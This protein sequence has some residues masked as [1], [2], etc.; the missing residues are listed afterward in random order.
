MAI[1]LQ[2]LI[3]KVGMDIS[4][5][6]SGIDDVMK[7]TSEA[8]SA[9]GSIGAGLSAGLTV[10]LAAIGAA[11]M[12]AS[13]QIKAGFRE[14]IVG[15]GEVGATLTGLK[16]S[17]KNVFAGVPESA[18]EVGVAIADLHR[19]LDLTGAP[20]EALATQF[21]NLS[22]IT[23]QSVE[24]LI[25]S[26]TRAFQAFKISTDQQAGSLDYLF[27]VFQKTGAPVQQL[28]DELTQFGPI[29]RSMGLDFQSSAALLGQFE[30]AGVPATAAMTGLRKALSEMA[31]AGL[32]TSNGFQ[33]VV[34]WIKQAGT[35]AQGLQRSIEIFG[36]KGGA[37]MFD[38]IKNGAVDIKN[39]ASGFSEA[40]NSINETTEKVET[41][42]AK[43]TKTWHE[44]QIALAPIGDILKG[45][46][47]DALVAIRPLIDSVG[48]LGK[49]FAG[50]NSEQKSVVVDL[51]LIAGAAGPVVL[52]F[53]KLVATGIFT[54]IVSL[55]GGV[56]GLGF[57]FSGM[58][59]PLT[60]ATAQIVTFLGIAGA[61]AGVIGGIGAAVAAQYALMKGMQSENPT[62]AGLAGGMNAAAALFGVGINTGIGSKSQLPGGQKMGPPVASGSAAA[63][64]AAATGGAGANALDAAAAKA[65]LDNAMGLLGVVDL[66]ANVKKFQD[67]YK[68]IAASGRATTE[69][70]E[71]AWQKV[72]DAM[73]A[74]GSLRNPWG[75]TQG[76]PKVFDAST[77]PTVESLIAT[78]AAAKVARDGFIAMKDAQKAATDQM[79]A[80]IEEENRFRQN[81]FDPSKI[82][83]GLIDGNES[84]GAFASPTTTIAQMQAL[85]DAAK[86][87]DKQFASMSNP[88]GSINK[89]AEKFI[90]GLEKGVVDVQKMALGADTVREA[91]SRLGVSSKTDLAQVWTDAATAQAAYN[92]GTISAWQN[93]QA[94]ISAIQKQITEGGW[95]SDL[96][97]QLDKIKDSLV[98]VGKAVHDNVKGAVDALDTGLAKAILDFH[99]F[100][101]D[102]LGTLKSL[103]ESVFT[104][105]FKALTKPLTDALTKTITDAITPIAKSI[106]GFL[107]IGVQSA[108]SVA[109]GA[110]SAAGGAASAAG[111]AASKAGGTA[112]S[113]ASSIGSI[114]GTVNMISGAVGAISSVIGNFQN[115]KMETTMNAI[116]ESTRYLKIGLVTQGDSLL[117]DSHEIR[118]MLSDFFGA[119]VNFG[120]LV[121][122]VKELTDAKDVSAQIRD[123]LA[124]P[125]VPLLQQ[126][127]DGA[128]V[129]AAKADDGSVIVPSGLFDSLIKTV[130]DASVDIVTSIK[131]GIQRLVDL[132]GITKDTPA[133]TP[134]E[135]VPVTVEPSPEAPATTT[136]YDPSIPYDTPQRVETVIPANQ[137]V[138]QTLLTVNQSIVNGCA[139]IVAQLQGMGGVGGTGTAAAATGDT[140]TTAPAGDTPATTSDIQTATYRLLDGT[141]ESTVS[142]V[143]GVQSVADAVQ[144]SAAR[145]IGGF[146]DLM[147]QIA[148]AAPNR[149]SPIEPRYF[150]SGF[151]DL[152]NQ[153]G[154]YTSELQQGAAKS[155]GD[156]S[157]VLNPNDPRNAGASAYTA[158]MPE[159][160]GSWSPVSY[161]PSGLNSGT[162]VTINNPI[163]RNPSDAQAI[164][165]LVRNQL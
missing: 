31:K 22:H 36:S 131:D 59:G 98:D 48:D 46:M 88:F 143:N 47:K 52:A 148:V 97:A 18:K 10:P 128:G 49:A 5:Y 2:E 77:L 78:G 157:N 58:E 35:E 138:V 51:G 130:K 122:L 119:K 21:L 14:I 44:F 106:A 26:T 120:V 60:A 45:F 133:P 64:G 125:I 117:N 54:N 140:G 71:A 4:D 155:V 109:G 104:T 33:D 23:G 43:L 135:P 95:T 146:T 94:Q 115:A 39:L 6:T 161:V 62:I 72:T 13:G 55:A 100:G 89:D 149:G 108:T 37:S 19:R 134:V 99:N 28:S 127:A 76:P 121:D 162:N 63:P 11:A 67:A 82:K 139:S 8:G 164:V 20:L 85:N 107:G 73:N 75:F 15:T 80:M 27:T 90:D 137:N 61:I 29:L 96:Q 103:G 153:P 16:D 163:F 156:F 136:P 141:G 124:N 84:V 7:K 50:L 30:K 56:R 144:Y 101:K 132:A 70:L 160:N 118:N 102:M 112:G 65:A 3:V 152:L 158:P 69:Q 111:G 114:A 151:T 159:L 79:A 32:D 113:A 165:D 123:V 9:L 129:G 86:E 87:L 40:G 38:A 74:A 92:K 93:A 147:S 150:G 24:P 83:A 53:N 42:G 142:I 154:A 105:A 25:Q 1:T 57:A 91:L 34:G 68:L 66:D 110:A 81:G 145:E 17:F 116:E 41:Q 12:E 126:I